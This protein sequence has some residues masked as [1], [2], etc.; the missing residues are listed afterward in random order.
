MAGIAIK[1][2]A[3][4]RIILPREFKTTVTKKSWS[5]APFE[6]VRAKH[7][8]KRTSRPVLF[9]LFIVKFLSYMTKHMKKTKAC[10]RFMGSKKEETMR[11]VPLGSSS[12]P[13]MLTGSM[14][15]MG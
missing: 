6:S 2:A 14:K 3:A 7:E 9:G 15:K 4:L 1:R 10:P 8:N 12:H 13:I 5:Q 11:G